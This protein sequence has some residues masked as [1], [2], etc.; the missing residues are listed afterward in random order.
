VDFDV[1]KEDLA[2]VFLQQNMALRPFAEIG[3]V[4]EFA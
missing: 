4:L 1:A 3:N 2:A